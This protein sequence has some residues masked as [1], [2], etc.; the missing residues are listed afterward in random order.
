MSEKIRDRAK[1]AADE[2]IWA[3]MLEESRAEM[4]ADP[5]LTDEEKR[6]L[7]QM[8]TLSDEE[9][10]PITCAGKPVSETIIEDRGER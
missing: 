6:Q 9:W 3:E 10:E 5:E 2:N 4:W 8:N 1:T 7:D